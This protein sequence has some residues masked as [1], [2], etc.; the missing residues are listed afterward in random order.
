[1]PTTLEERQA[2]VDQLSP[3]YGRY[4]SPV[5][6]LA[7]TPRRDLAQSACDRLVDELATSCPVAAALT[8]SGDR[9]VRLDAPEHGQ[10]PQAA[11]DRFAAE[12]LYR[13]GRTP[14]RSVQEHRATFAPSA[15][16]ISPAVMSAATA[17]STKALQDDQ[18]L[19][20]ERA[21]I[22]VITRRHVATRTP[23]SENDAARLLADVQDI[24]LRDHAW[25]GITRAEALDHGELWKDL[26][27][28]APQGTEAPAASLAAFSFWVSGDGMSA[29][30]SL[31]RIPEGQNYSLAS[32]LS[33]AMRA[34]LDPKS[35]PIP[36]ELPADVIN[37][38]N[39]TPTGLRH[40]RRE[41]PHPP[42]PPSNGV[43]R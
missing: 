36:H 4:A 38:G 33:T 26:L 43:S 8:V 41:P 20:E 11:R 17:A 13:D 39:S 22:G 30:A 29:R 42:S 34:G 21:W 16:I 27:T 12:A 2:M 14:Y 37:G 24:G 18:L 32:L 6:L 19:S 35:Y 7:Y 5:I 9:W 15:Q 3:V 1:M 31:E 28:R 25:S 10:V 23:L 40:D